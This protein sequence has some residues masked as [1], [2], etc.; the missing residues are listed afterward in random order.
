[1]LA[2][3]RFFH[4]FTTPNG[5]CIYVPLYVNAWHDVIAYYSA[6][7]QWILVL[8][9]MFSFVM[10]DSAENFVAFLTSTLAFLKLLAWVL[11]RLW[12]YQDQVIYSY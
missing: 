10:H 5:P 8:D 6:R 7:L 3:T 9:V 12:F 2:V 11:V 4:S 1:M